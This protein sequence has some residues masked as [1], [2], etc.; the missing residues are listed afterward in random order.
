MQPK[1]TTMAHKKHITRTKEEKQ[2]TWSRYTRWWQACL[3][4]DRQCQ[5]RALDRRQD[6]GVWSLPA[7]EKQKLRLRKRTTLCNICFS[8]KQGCKG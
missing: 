7:T 8:R 1:I 3:G 2:D 4:A 5:T 6:Y